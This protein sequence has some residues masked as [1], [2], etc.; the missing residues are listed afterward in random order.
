MK[1]IYSDQNGTLTTSYA[2]FGVIPYGHSI[3]GWIYFDPTNPLGCEPFGEFDFNYN[4]KSEVIPIILVKRGECSFVKKVRNIERIG[5]KVGIVVDDKIED[6]QYVIM[7]DD[8]TGS[9][10]WIPSMLIG[11]SDGLNMIDF[12]M[13]YGGTPSVKVSK[14]ADEGSGKNKAGEGDD[15]EPDDIVPPKNKGKN[16]SKGKADKIDP[17]DAKTLEMAQIIITFNMENPDNR[18]EYDIWFTSTDDRALDFIDNFKEYDK[19]FGESVLMTPHYVTFDCSDCDASFKSK[20]CFGNGKFCALNHK[21][22][23]MNGQ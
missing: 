13:K 8:G 9:G 19:L 1:D 3:K 16:D 20:E 6:V 21:Q 5:G 10:I 4:S 7:S 23:K 2:N 15:T 17:K 12:L 14:S 11:R 18:V 22:I